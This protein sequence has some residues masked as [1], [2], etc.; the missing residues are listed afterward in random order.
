MEHGIIKTVVKVFDFQCLLST[1]TLQ[2]NSSVMMSATHRNFHFAKKQFLL[3]FMVKGLLLLGHG[4]YSAVWWSFV[5]KISIYRSG[6]TL[7]QKNHV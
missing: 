2:L 1:L 4:Y 6:I 7:A 5:N 3:F